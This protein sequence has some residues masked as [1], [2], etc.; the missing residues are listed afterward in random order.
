MVDSRWAQRELGR[1]VV[2]VFNNL[3]AHS[4]ATKVRPA[5]AP[6]RIA[7]TVSGNDPAAK[8]L[9]LRLVDEAG[10]EGVDASSLA[11]SWRQQTGTPPAYCTDLAASEVPAALALADRRKAP[12]LRDLAMER[13][14]HLPAADLE[15]M[16]TG[17]YPAGHVDKV[18]AL[19][20]A[21][22]WPQKADFLIPAAGTR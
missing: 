6:D 15:A 14:M 22:S 7:L 10:F 9:A 3:F 19:V 12:R 21:A 8:A 20:R 5:G 13:I 16:M 11:D 1:P 4:L 2:K 18:V 17:G